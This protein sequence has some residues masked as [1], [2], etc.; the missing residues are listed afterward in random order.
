MEAGRAGSAVGTF[1]DSIEE[2]VWRV[3]E[4]HFPKVVM[5]TIFVCSISEVFVGS[6]NFFVVAYFTD[7]LYNGTLTH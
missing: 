4:V 1:Y 5:F 3:L 6:F 2:T 7:V